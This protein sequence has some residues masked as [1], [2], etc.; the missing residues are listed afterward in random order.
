MVEQNTVADL[1][2][3]EVVSRLKVAHARP[4]GAA[5]AD[6]VIPGV[7]LRLLLDHP[8]AGRPISLLR[9]GFGFSGNSFLAGC[10]PDSHRG[11]SFSFSIVT[12]ERSFN[13]RIG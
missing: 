10:F 4:V 1:H 7:S 11:C 8:D 5:I 6:K 2:L 3:S 12:I 9:R 13:L